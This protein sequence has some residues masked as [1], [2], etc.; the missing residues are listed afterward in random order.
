MAD[1][2]IY[3]PII[4]TMAHA[5]HV[6]REREREREK[7]REREREKERE[8][9]RERK[10]ERERERGDDLLEVGVQTLFSDP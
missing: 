2:F 7:E 4:Y 9:E 1:S 10:R 3:T 5:S 6:V 8:R